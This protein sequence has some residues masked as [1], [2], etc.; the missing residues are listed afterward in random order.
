MKVIRRIIC[1]FLLFLFGVAVVTQAA[2]S[3]VNRLIYHARMVKSFSQYLPQEKVYV[4]FDN[5]SYYQSDP[6]WF[7]CYVVNSGPNSAT[8]L[9]KTLYVELL[10]PGGQ[11]VERQILKIENGRCHGN[12]TLNRLP[13]YSGFYEVRAYTKYMLNFGDDG[14]FSRLLPVFDPPAE[15]G[16]Y[17]QRNM[18]RYGTG[19]YMMERK[20][21]EKG[22]KLNLR[23]FPEGGNL[24]E[25]IPSEIA[26]EA[27]DEKGLPVELTGSVGAAGRET[28]FST[29][30][31][32][33]GA[34]TYTPGPGTQ[35]VTVRY[36]DQSY[37]FDLPEALPQGFVLHVDNLSEADSVA[38]TV[39]KNAGT[40][41]AMLGL[42]VVSGG[43]LQNVYL[44][45]A[46]DEEPVNFKLDKTK[47]APGVTRLVL[48]DSSAEI[49]GD[50]LIFTGTG[51]RLDIRADVPEKLAPFAPVDLEFSLA[52][53]E[54]EAV[55]QPFSLSVRDGDDEVFSGRNALTDLLLMSEIKGYVR[56]P[57]YYFE[58]TDSLRR[59]ALDLLLMVQG[60]RRYSWKQQAG[61]EPFDLKYEPEQGIVTRGQVVSAV[62]H[63]PKPGVQVSSFLL[64]HEDD[65]DTE[66]RAEVMETDSLGRF[67]FVEDI[68]GKWNLVLA[69]TTE[70]G[71]KKNY[72]VMLDRFFSPAPRKYRLAEME[73]GLVPPE[74]KDTVTVDGDLTDE[75][76]IETESIISVYED[77]LSGTGIAG[78][79]HRLKGI[80]VTAKD[81]REKDIYKDRSESVAYYDVHSELDDLKDEGTYIRDDIHVLL[82]KI[83]KYFFHSV[84]DD[85]L[86]YKGKLPIFVVN[87][88]NFNEEEPVLYKILRLEAI[89]SLYI[90]EDLSTICLYG[91]PTLSRFDILDKYSCV[92]F[93][94]T[95]PDGM[96][97]VSPAKG[98]R[99]TLLQGYSPARDFYHPDYSSV[100]P[101]TDY[102][103][104]LYWNPSV[105]PD[106]T[107]KAKIR[108]FNNG[109]CRRLRINAET[110]TP[111]GAIGVY[112][113]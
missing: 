73:V 108:F 15:E 38:V 28:A 81:S 48:Y 17:R 111:Q 42:A 46:A 18:H 6:I 103:R 32:G 89:K 4:Q 41:A 62:R 13:F 14:I 70:E 12:F 106:S 60:W 57:S 97:P 110:V 45:D 59:Q 10:N 2:D 24:V 53:P 9:S 51:S 91:P 82:A 67:S 55:R 64:R 104:T 58:D 66:H 7:S 43:V 72:K 87:Y 65:I 112:E 11:V 49:L 39:R 113:K 90:N 93:I 8:R 99:K 3:V 94:E 21:P 88:V 35:P 23:F 68:V 25:G 83:N 71:K 40:P 79:I 33:R 16:E 31:G 86:W 100:P 47:F 29:V 34:F 63:V 69:V 27:T 75:E 56:N 5:T 101:E 78:K 44:V 92:V 102:R 1:P 77:S 74:K 96:A 61:L 37:T 50:R 54:G 84:K 76:D 80:T 52:G 36:R 98:V 30:H 95:Y 107:G 22:K 19:A 26:F 105:A 109:R 85:V 20:K